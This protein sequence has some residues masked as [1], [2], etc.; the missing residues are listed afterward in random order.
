[1]LKSSLLALTSNVVYPIKLTSI[2]ASSATS[3]EKFPSKSVE[4]PLLVPFSITV[5]PGSGSPPSSSTVPLMLRCAHPLNASSIK[6]ND[7][8]KCFFIFI[9]IVNKKL[10]VHVFFRLLKQDS[11]ELKK[12]NKSLYSLFILG[13]TNSYPRFSIDLIK[14]TKSKSDFIFLYSFFSR[15]TLFLSSSRKNLTILLVFG[16]M[17]T[18]VDPSTL[19]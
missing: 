11:I 5:A 15:L 3:M 10:N 13:M 4:T 6:A 2:T 7:S 9:Y 12:G 16:S 19:K 8:S 14:L 18:A 17:G 1:M